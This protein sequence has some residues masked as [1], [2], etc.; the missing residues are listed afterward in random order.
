MINTDLLHRT[1]H[2]VFILSAIFISGC[3]SDMEPVDCF[4]IEV[5][6]SDRC[7]GGMLVSVKNS[8]GIGEAITYYDG[9]NFKNVIRVYTLNSI[10]ESKT[11]F[12]QI[13]EFDPRRDNDFLRI[14]QWLYAPFP[15]PT[16]V[17]TFWSEEPC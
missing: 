13:R 12:I 10:P 2:F 8:E 1:L 15:V 7:G 4:E 6:G 9:T 5:I 14:C 17:A 11:A 16:K 3:Q